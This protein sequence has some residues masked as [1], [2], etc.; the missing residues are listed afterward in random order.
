MANAHDDEVGLAASTP[1]A[2][3]PF[4]SKYIVTPEQMT[5]WG[6]PEHEHASFR[7]AKFQY[8]Y[9]ML[10]WL[11]PELAQHT[12]FTSPLDLSVEE[13]RALVCR[14]QR[15]KAMRTSFSE[16]QVEEVTD[17][18]LR[19]LAERIDAHLALDARLASCFVKLNTRSPKD[20]PIYCDDYGDT[21]ALYQ[22]EIARVPVAQRTLERELEAFVVAS[23]RAMRVSNG[24]QAIEL[25][26]R[27]ERVA[28]DIVRTIGYG[29]AHFS[30]QLVFREWD[31]A[32]V[33]RPACEFRGFVSGG[34]L[35][36]LSSYFTFLYDPDT[37]AQA[38]AIAERV[39][40]FHA[41][42]TALIPH[43]S[44]VIDFA[45]LPERIVVIET[46]PFHVLAGAAHFSWRLDRERFLNGPFEMRVTRAPYAGEP[47][48]QHGA[49]SML[50]RP[51]REFIADVRAPDSP[52]VRQAAALRAPEPAPEAE[53]PS[54]VVL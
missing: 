29:G 19:H 51:W 52:A 4:A 36:A 12:M 40:A 24:A 25:L 50:P 45:V 9:D 49:L 22:A 43:D 16:G 41:S 14:Y 42:I 54:C 32:I 10:S 6:I 53:A 27:S 44:Y 8:A 2:V 15:R 26:S 38:D 46:N 39:R 47:G 13:A 28:S 34:T 23:T 7:N 20:V 11:T 37:A 1:G 33:A 3:S 35:N 5:A 18:L 30:W 21:R 48:S 17:A 31:D